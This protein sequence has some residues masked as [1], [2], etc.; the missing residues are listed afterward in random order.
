M[1][2]RN[3]MACL[4]LLG[5][6][7]LLLPA[8]ARPQNSSDTPEQADVAGPPPARVRLVLNGSFWPGTT[9]TFGDI[10]TF[11]EYAEQTT[12]RTSYEGQS[13]FG[14]GVALQ[15]NVFRNLG[16]LVGYSKVSRDET[17]NVDVSRP[18]PLHF[19]RPRS[20][21]AELSGYSYSEGAIQIDLAYGRGAGHLDWSLFAGL[22]LFQVE[23]ELVTSP[24]FIDV[25]PYDSL[26]VDSTTRTT[27]ESSPTGF[28][29]GGRVDY[30][31]GQSG[32]FGLGVQLLYSAGTAKF[33]ATPGAQGF[34]LDVGGL[35]VAAGVRLYF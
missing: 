2:R 5:A 29:I 1:M 11:P 20:A 27:A 3:S 35:Q 18:H 4:T 22:T 25:Y 10:Q 12:V 21:S 28:N 14:P 24:T 8:V 26:T 13:A 32:R 30:R 31:L 6:L 9:P 7:L 17:G 16:I 33:Q 34:S 23:A 15:V 19:D